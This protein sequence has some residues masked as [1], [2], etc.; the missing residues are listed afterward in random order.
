MSSQNSE[1]QRSSVHTGYADQRRRTRWSTGK[2][3]ERL[4]TITRFRTGIAFPAKR[5]SSGWRRTS[6]RKKALC[7]RRTKFRARPS[8][9]VATPGPEPGG[10][11]LPDDPEDLRPRRLRLAHVGRDAQLPAGLGADALDRHAR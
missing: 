10:V 2:R 11:V 6:A 7:A 1:S 4:P 8:R 9:L 5:G 3:S